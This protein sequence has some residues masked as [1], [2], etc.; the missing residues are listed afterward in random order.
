MK[1][2]SAASIPHPGSSSRIAM[3]RPCR[4]TELDRVLDIIN[5]GATAYK[6]I[7]PRD[8]YHEPYMS[9]DELRAEFD[10]M[11]FYGY[12]LA[13]EMV[14]VGALQTVK[15]VTLIRH[16]YVRTDQQRLGV[17][18]ALLRHLT[19]LTETSRLLVGTWADAWSVGFYEKHD[20]SRRPDSDTLLRAYWTIPRRQRETSVVL[21]KSL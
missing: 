18:T 13:S 16:L 19:A 21:E 9:L 10:V 8:C 20:F 12:D 14:G 17:G 4:S 7:I 3:I 6:G 2:P 11:S 5:D 1:G 15:D